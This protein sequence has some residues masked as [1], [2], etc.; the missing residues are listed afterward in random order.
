[1][2]STPATA[3]SFS[4]KYGSFV[5]KAGSKFGFSNLAALFEDD[6]DTSKNLEGFAPQFKVQTLIKGRPSSLTYMTPKTQT[7]IAEFSLTPEGTG[8]SVGTVTDT[9]P[10]TPTQTVSQPTTGGS[11]AALEQ[12]APTVEEKANRLLSSFIGPEGTSGYIG[13]AGIQRAQEYGYSPAQ[14]KAMAQQEGLQFGQQAAQGLGVQAPSFAAPAA[15]VSQPASAP[16]P[17]AAPAPTKASPISAFANT[18]AQG[19]QSIGLAGLQR[20]AEA[21]GITVEQAARRA[22][23]QGLTLGGAARKLL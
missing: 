1:M 16:T 6:E 22:E 3:S 17:Q 15:V 11:S 10:Q 23:K 2:T 21:K 8:S 7:Q 13:Q 18:A 14:I 20:A 4:N 19:Q 9:T 12:P 5:R